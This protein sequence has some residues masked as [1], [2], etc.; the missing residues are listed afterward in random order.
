MSQSS[1][2]Q[3]EED[4]PL[5]GQRVLVTRPAHQAADFMAGL[6]RLG[7][8]PIAFP[9]IE[10]AAV[11]DTTALDNAI[12]QLMGWAAALRAAVA[13]P[14]RPFDWLALTSANGV[15]A[16]WERL[17]AAGGDSRSLAALNI[18]AIGPATA[19]A[20]HSRSILPD[21]VPLEYTAEGV[22]AA[23]DQLGPVAGQHFLLTRADI[24]RQTLAAGLR[25]RGATVTEIPAYRTVPV[26]SGAFPPP[27][28]IVTFTSS[29]TVQGYV[30]CLGDVSPA[31]ALAGCRVVCIGPVTA[32]TARNLGVPVTAV[33]EEY[34]IDGILQL[35][36]GG[37]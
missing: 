5:L 20:L 17:H 16:V 35:L 18:A 10:I 1:P 22:L 2:L 34:T 23:F 29:S 19:A 33:A 27:A 12:S 13:P 4:Y 36:K 7:A 14:A 37:K 15:T 25:E 24:A 6:R 9:T 11:Q 32:T 3:A 31:Q 8:E 28:D 30:N 21:L 26:Q